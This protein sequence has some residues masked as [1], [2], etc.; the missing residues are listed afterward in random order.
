MHDA[1]GRLTEGGRGDAGPPSA[2]A[3]ESSAV[4]ARR[5]EALAALVPPL[6]HKLGNALGGVVGLTDLVER[7]G[8]T[9]GS[10]GLLASARG[11]A[12]LATELVRLLAQVARAPAG[13]TDAEDV[14]Q[15]ALRA[16][17]LLEPLAHTLSARL[18]PAKRMGSLVVRSDGA[19]LFQWFVTAGV[20]VLATGPG[21]R[22]AVLRLAVRRRAADLELVCLAAWRE[23]PPRASL[24]ALDGPPGTAGAA[25]VRA[26][27]RKL[28]LRLPLEAV[29]TPDSR[30]VR[31]GGAGRVLLVL[32][33]DDLLAELVEMLLAESGFTVERVK[34]AA[35]LAQRIGGAPVHLALVGASSATSVEWPG[36]EVAMKGRCSVA[37]LGEPEL[38]ALRPLAF[39]AKPF[40]PGEL[41]AFVR[42]RLR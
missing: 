19:A 13:R 21:A 15:L 38:A 35:A 8:G 29:I 12:E 42:E 23:P 5:L 34:D 16:G 2:G 22:P 3:P 20:E 1:A 24:A 31:T 9:A 30:A 36:I 25:Q 26:R 40:R 14:G 27:A 4:R 10:L 17:E 32:E 37:L 28:C 18:L 11:Q 39:L 33:R 7:R 41:L 6:V